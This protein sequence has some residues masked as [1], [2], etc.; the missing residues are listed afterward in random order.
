VTEARRGD[1]APFEK[2]MREASLPDA[3]IR[4]FERD[5]ERLASGARGTISEADI[6]PVA[7]LPTRD[8]LQCHEAEGQEALGRTAV[9][10]LNGGLG[11]SMGMRRAKS[12]LTLKRELSFLDV[13][14][15]QVLHLR[16][17]HGGAVPLVLM[18][19]FRTRDDSL[20]ALAAYP[21]LACGALPLDFLQ[22]KVPRIWADDLSPVEWP[23]QPELEWCPPGHGD[24]YLALSTS[25]MLSRLLEAGCDYAF[26]SNSDNL[27]A[28]LDPV[29]LGWMAA[30]RIPFVLEVCRRTEVHRKG[31]HLA[32]LHGAGLVLREV[33]QCPPGEEEAFQDVGRHGW[34]NTNNLW[35][36]LRALERLLAER[37]G[38]LGLPMI[39]NEKTVDPNDAASRRVVQ[40][41][42]AM[43]AAISVFDGARAVSVSGQRFAPVKTTADLLVVWS[44]AYELSPDWRLVPAPG[45]EAPVVDLAP[46]HYRSVD[47][48]E[49]R[50]PLGAPSLRGCRRLSIEGDVRFGAGVVCR[51]D[52]RVRARGP[53]SVADGT[54]LEGEI[55]LD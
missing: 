34:F 6:E 47:Q 33:A 27:G 10:K 4:S 42:T 1:F 51:G 32:T 36:D 50:F 46:A 31:G 19:S 37:D 44:D 54:S 16:K 21:E 35:V 41:E 22:H 7:E 11:T 20:E 3:A 26:V 48:L 43:G 55:F 18:N 53:A 49:E 15:R 9:I 8:G 40:L 25:G 28:V 39:R 13:I 52:V 14:A 2:K 23:A 17:V 30:E 29:L 45:V 12:L 24:L 38:V 5:Y